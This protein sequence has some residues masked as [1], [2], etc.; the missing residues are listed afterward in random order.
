MTAGHCE[1][2]LSLCAVRCA[3]GMFKTGD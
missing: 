1:Y 2:T 3:F